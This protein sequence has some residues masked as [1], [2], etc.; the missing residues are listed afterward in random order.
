MGKSI[1]GFEADL[2]AFA[3]LVDVEL[4]QV[5]HRIA[6]E[7]FSKIVQRTPV[8]TG[9]ARSNWIMTEGEPSGAIPHGENVTFTASQASLMASI[10]RISQV[11]PGVKVIFVTNNLPYI[12][13]LEEGGYGDGPKTVGGYSIQAPAGMVKLALAEV[14]AGILEETARRT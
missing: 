7:V 12:I 14:E 3:K 8:D 1:H 11:T 4:D 6:L 9:R 5:I 10:N 2:T 13:T